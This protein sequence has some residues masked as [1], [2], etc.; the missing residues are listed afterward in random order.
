[1]MKDIL[2]I[3]PSLGIRT[4]IFETIYSV[5]KLN[6]SRIDHVIIG[7]S[8][9][10]ILLARFGDAVHVIEEVSKGG[11]YAAINQVLAHHATSYK[12][13][14]YI[15]DDD[16]LCSGFL[17]LIDA[18]DEDPNLHAAFG[19]VMR[20]FDCGKPM[21]ILPFSKSASDFLVLAPH[22]VPTLTQQGVLCRSQVYVQLGGFSESLKL[23]SLAAD[24]M[25]Y[26]GPSVQPGYKLYLI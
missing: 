5:S 3:T 26:I 25:I 15:N 18:L 19:K 17:R 11:V 22:N 1:M 24:F 7:P 13:I 14:S 20:V 2:I 6:L 10:K 4:S 8:S 16:V 9:L 23:L 12:Y 21:H